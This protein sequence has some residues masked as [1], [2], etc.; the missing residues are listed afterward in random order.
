MLPFSFLSTSDL[1]SGRGLKRFPVRVP[2][3][4]TQSLRLCLFLA[5]FQ[6]LL[7]TSSLSHSLSLFLS[8][9]LSLTL[10][11]SSSFFPP[12]MGVER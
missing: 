9:S 7:S 12:M 10:S 5:L 4:T 3:L 2:F 6:I 11:V 1:F 8:L